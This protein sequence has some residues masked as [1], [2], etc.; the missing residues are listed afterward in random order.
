MV[1]GIDVSKA[2]FDVALLVDE[3]TLDSV[4]GRHRVFANSPKGFEELARWLR[5]QGVSV[6]HACMEATGSYGIA[7]A[8][9]LVQEGHTV[10]VVNPKRINPWR[11]KDKSRM[12]RNKTDKQD[13]LVIAR[14]CLKETPE[15]WHP[16]APEV[17]ELQALVRRLETLK[18]LRQQEENRLEGRPTEAVRDSTAAMLAYLNEQITAVEAAIE[19]HIDQHPE[20]KRQVE[21]LKSIPGIGAVTARKLLAELTFTNFKDAREVAAFTGLAPSQ[22]QSGSSV[23]GRGHLSKVGSKKLRKILYFPAINARRFNP[24]I[25]LFCDN[26]LA[27]GKPKLVVVCA[28]MRKLLHLAFGVLKSGRPF[29]PEHSS[30]LLS[31]GA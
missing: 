17:K 16:P 27:R 3:D 12:Q 31:V 7:L 29:D 11:A 5:K 21:L 19:S 8:E 2:S 28:A 26:L 25:K 4:K 23:R 24:V 1:L 22:Y 9:F 30:H 14:F 15:P 18:E 13:A 6:L 10:S 20:L